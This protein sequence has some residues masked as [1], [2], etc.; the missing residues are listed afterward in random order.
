MS[1]G[2]VRATINSEEKGY[3]LTLDFYNRKSKIVSSESI[4]FFSEKRELSEWE[5]ALDVGSIN[6]VAH[7]KI[8]D[9]YRDTFKRR[10][11]EQITKSLAIGQQHLLQNG[12]QIVLVVDIGNK[13]PFKRYEIIADLEK[14]PIQ[15]TEEVVLNYLKSPT[16]TRQLPIED[17]RKLIYSLGKS[18]FVIAEGSLKQELLA[19]FKPMEREFLQAANGTVFCEIVEHVMNAAKFGFEAC[20]AGSSD[21][22]EPILLHRFVHRIVGNNLLL[23][24]QSIVIYPPPYHD[25][26]LEGVLYSRVM[27]VSKI[28]KATVH[29]NEGTTQYV[30]SVVRALPAVFGLSSPDKAGSPFPLSKND[31]QGI[32]SISPGPSGFGIPLPRAGSW[33]ASAEQAFEYNVIQHQQEEFL[34]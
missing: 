30:V 13:P 11:V 31:E 3:S 10:D 9:I 18:V 8:G 27:V 16:G 5:R 22:L 33:S 15:E 23:C 17:V 32:R 1:I 29:E 6:G 19:R 12:G 7:Q 28:F 2:G 14:Q 4:Q 26:A 20:L 24:S 21:N 34:V 25:V